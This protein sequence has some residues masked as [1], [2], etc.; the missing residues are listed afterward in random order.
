MSTVKTAIALYDGVTSP[1]AAMHRAMNIVINSFET[2]QNASGNAVDVSAIQE[3]REELARAE[4]AFDAIEDSIRNADQQQQ[5]F[6][7][8]IRGGASAADGLMSKLKGIAATVG[9]MI[10]L[11]KVLNLSDELAST[12]ARLSLIV[13]DGCHNPLKK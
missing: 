4:T 11:N 9:G 7:G 8:S 6:N 5:R 2:M 3:A 13:D 12:K 10:G 1:L